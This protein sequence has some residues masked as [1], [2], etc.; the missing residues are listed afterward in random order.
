MERMLAAASAPRPRMEPS[1]AA[2]EQPAA[3]KREHAPASASRLFSL[4]SM[5]RIPHRSGPTWIQR[6]LPGLRTWWS[7]RG[8]LLWLTI[9]TVWWPRVSAAILPKVREP[10]AAGRIVLL[11]WT[12]EFRRDWKA[13][14]NSIDLA[15]LRTSLRRWLRQPLPSKQ[16]SPGKN[17]PV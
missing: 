13:M 6:V 5:N 3:P 11:R 7:L 4:D 16:I 10:L 12:F 9:I 14:I 17:Q 2:H 8:S 1:K 15:Q